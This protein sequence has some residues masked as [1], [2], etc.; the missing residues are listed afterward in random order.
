MALRPE[1]VD[2]IGLHFLYDTDQVGRVGQVAVVQEEP[3]VFFVRILVEMIDA[4]GVEEAAASFDA[5]DFVVF[6]KQQLGQV[7]SVLPGNASNQRRPSFH[8]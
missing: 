4:L 5:V 1:V 8:A 7:R 6:A 2:L 3:D